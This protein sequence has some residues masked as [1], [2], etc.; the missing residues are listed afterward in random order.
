MVS[1]MQ[2][3]YKLDL[4]M[5]HSLTGLK[6]CIL[7]HKLDIVHI[8]TI[9]Q[10]YSFREK[11]HCIKLSYIYFKSMCHNSVEITFINILLL[12]TSFITPFIVFI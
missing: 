8:Y 5:L 7:L 11:M 9:K 10:L 12:I 2:K 3:F 6:K 4:Q 1:P